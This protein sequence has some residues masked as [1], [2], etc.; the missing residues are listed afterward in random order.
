M[1]L[2]DIINT[3]T[4]LVALFIPVAFIIFAFA[5]NLFMLIASTGDAKKMQ[6]A[7][8]RLIWSI[9]AMFVFFSLIGIITVLRLTFFGDDTHPTVP[10]EQPPNIFH[11]LEY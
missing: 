5:W 2:T 7:K 3:M 4:G 10:L 1:T 6:Q 11:L 9:V 8:A